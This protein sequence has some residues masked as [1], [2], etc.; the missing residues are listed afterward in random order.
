[1]W[2]FEGKDTEISNNRRER[3]GKR[4]KRE[5]NYHPPTEFEAWGGT[6]TP[7]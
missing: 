6:V 4:R 3:E 5:T 2:R 1:M 7:T